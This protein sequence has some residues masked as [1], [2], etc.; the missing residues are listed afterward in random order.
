MNGIVA[1]LISMFSMGLSDALWRK[2]IGKLVVEEAIIYRT[3]FSL[4]FFVV[5]LFFDL[6]KTTE[7]AQGVLGLNIWI[8][9][10]LVCCISYFGLFFFNKALKYS[11]TGLVVI[12]T[13][14]SY[15][16][17]QLAAFI[18]L[19]ESPSEGYILPFALF[20]LSIIVSDYSSIFKFKLSKGVWFALLA[21]F[22]WGV[23][24]PLVSIPAKQIGYVKTGFVSESSVMLMSIV[25]LFFLQKKNKEEENG[26]G[27][28]EQGERRGVQN[29]IQIANG[30]SFSFKYY[31]KRLLD[32]K[33]GNRKLS[34]ARFKTDLIYFVFLGLLS[35]VGVLF[36][37]LSY[38]KIPVY[39]AS[40]ISS[41]TH[42]VTIVLAWILFK[43]KLKIHQY[44]AALI[45]VVAIF[46]LTQMM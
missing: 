4:L 27:K 23:T 36:N 17:G 1:Q 39:I 8:F 32:K 24:I 16:F 10:Y 41:C 19:G 22:F 20:I 21:S 40:S 11:S 43:E 14:S 15:L 44:I 3:V 2:P 31:H 45:S 30:N 18:L 42:L 35:G 13:T 25:G 37:N 28:T 29:E 38:T 6:N 46:L 9:T 34:L 7:I 12:V 5:L 26:E 33:N